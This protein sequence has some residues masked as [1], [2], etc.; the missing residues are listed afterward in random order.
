MQETYPHGAAKSCQADT[1][2]PR[3]A[4]PHLLWDPNEIFEFGKKKIAHVPCLV[5]HLCRPHSQPR[6]LRNAVQHQ[7]RSTYAMFPK[8]SLFIPLI[9]WSVHKTAKSHYSLRQVCP[10]VRIN[11]LLFVKPIT[12][13]PLQ[14]ATSDAD[15]VVCTQH[16]PVRNTDTRRARTRSFWTVH[17]VFKMSV[18]THGI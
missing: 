1:C 9:F 15:L 8:T 18:C 6:F 2:S 7:Y 3:Q 14:D 4:I 17:E 11:M 12:S 5:S 13:L 10:S 16:R